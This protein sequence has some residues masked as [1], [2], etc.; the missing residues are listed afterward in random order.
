[1]PAQSNPYQ[2]AADVLLHETGCVVRKWRQNNTGVAFTT[3]PDWGIEAPR[4][5]GP[6]S[7]GVFAHEIGHQVLHRHNS[8]PR[9]LEEIEAW[10]YALKQFENHGLAGYD[11]AQLNAAKGITWAARKAS[12]RCSWESAYKILNRVPDWVDDLFPSDVWG[13]LLERIEG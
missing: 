4:P 2:D 7:F 1:M 12:K 10:E 5:R 11:A 3:A 9:W 13:A 6:I 8:A